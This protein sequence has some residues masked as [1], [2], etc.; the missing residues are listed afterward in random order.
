MV[1]ELLGKI[2]QAKEDGHQVASICL[3]LLKAFDTL[4]H[5]VLISKLEQH[6]IRGLPLT[7]FKS[8]LEGRSLIAK[9][10]VSSSKIS[11]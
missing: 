6:G 7:W 9:V 11:Y 4:D 5:K 10:L 2:L 8:Y 1:Q 3:D